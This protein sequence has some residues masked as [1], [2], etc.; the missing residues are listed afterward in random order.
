[1]CWPFGNLQFTWDGRKYTDS[2][3]PHDGIAHHAVTVTAMQV[4]D[5]VAPTTISDWPVGVY[6]ARLDVGLL[7]RTDVCKTGTP[8]WRLKKR[9]SLA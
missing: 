6:Y 1:M 7:P 9:S 2:F 8:I 4:A 3:R 5:P